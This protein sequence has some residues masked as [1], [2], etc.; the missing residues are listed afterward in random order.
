MLLTNAVTFHASS[1][2]PLG[3]CIPDK[4]SEE[5]SES[6]KIRYEKNP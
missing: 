6:G 4:M 2:R 3:D 1:S 5:F